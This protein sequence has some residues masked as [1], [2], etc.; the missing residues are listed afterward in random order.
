M[1][2]KGIIQNDMRFL[3]SVKDYGLSSHPAEGNFS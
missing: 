2:S 3:I 1:F